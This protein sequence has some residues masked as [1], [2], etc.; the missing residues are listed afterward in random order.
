MIQMRGKRALSNRFRSTS[1]QD[2]LDDA[3]VSWTF[4]ICFGYL[5]LETIE[6]LPFETQGDEISIEGLTKS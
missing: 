2:L 3:P 4:N 1:H 6:P 5:L